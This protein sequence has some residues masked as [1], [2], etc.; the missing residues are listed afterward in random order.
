MKYPLRT[1]EK[2]NWC[3]AACLEA[4]LRFRRNQQS[5]SQV[6][7]AHEL[8]INQNGLDSF[9]LT[10]DINRFL[11]KYNLGCRHRNPFENHMGPEYTLIEEFYDFQDV[12][13]AYDYL[14]M[15]KIHNPLGKIGKHFSLITGFEKDKIE[16]QDP[17]KG[18]PV[19]V[20]LYSLLDAMQAREDRRY[21][22]Y[23]IGEME[24]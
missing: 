20:S 23:I 9:D 15:H 10:F 4:V 5:A 7:I 8:R 16:L 12:M 24:K 19:N 6:E 17:S 21:G 1:Q 11:K 18:E 3:V 2:D 13:V 14:K 22:F